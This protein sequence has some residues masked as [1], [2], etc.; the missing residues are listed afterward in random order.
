M[1]ITGKGE[2]YLNELYV[3]K[4][5]LRNITSIEM[6]AVYPHGNAVKFWSYIAGPNQLAS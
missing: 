1:W 4:T 6:G 5:A 3:T 2:Q